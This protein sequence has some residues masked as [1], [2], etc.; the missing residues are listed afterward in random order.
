MTAFA[1]FVPTVERRWLF[2]AAALLWGLAGLMLLGRAVGW[3]APE[4]A[5]SADPL[6]ALGIAVGIVI[7]RFKFAWIAEKNIKR[8]NSLSERANLFCFQSRMTYLLIALMMALG[9][10]LR[11]S[12]VPKPDLA[13]LYIG[14]GLGLVLASSRYARRC[15]G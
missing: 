11:S 2:L 4:R 1:R 12:P 15:L 14:I 7:Y 5:T 8:I 10:V 13:V 3:L 6:A 9:I